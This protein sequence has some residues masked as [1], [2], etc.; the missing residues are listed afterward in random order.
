M[1][2][3]KDSLSTAPLTPPLTGLQAHLA[4]F[5]RDGDGV[6]WPLDTWVLVFF[7][8]TAAGL[9]AGLVLIARL[10]GYHLGM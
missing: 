8:S 1:A 5:D 3:P 9:P 2:P 4:F 10:S 7:S 6:L